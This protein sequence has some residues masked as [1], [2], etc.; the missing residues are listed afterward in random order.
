M[1]KR[2][3]CVIAYVILLYS[4]GRFC[5][6]SQSNLPQRGASTPCAVVQTLIMS[7]ADR[8]SIRHLP[9]E[10][11]GERTSEFGPA[12]LAIQRARSTEAP[13]RCAA[14]DREEKRRRRDENKQQRGGKSRQRDSRVLHRCYRDGHYTPV[15]A[16]R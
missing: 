10:P 16:L 13:I 14:G 1:L 11:Q 12:I 2:R 6:R 7:V 15:T 5:S 9:H 3:Y 8:D 4:D